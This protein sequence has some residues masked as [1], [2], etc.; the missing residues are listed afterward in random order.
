MRLLAEKGFSR[1]QI[2]QRL[3]ISH[4]DIEIF[5]ESENAPFDYE[6]VD[7]SNNHKI[8]EIID[9]KKI[10]KFWPQRGY[11]TSIRS[12]S[13]EKILPASLNNIALINDKIKFMEWLDDSYTPEQAHVTSTNQASEK[14]TEYIRKRKN[15]CVK[16]VHGVNGHGYWRI[17]SEDNIRFLMNPDAREIGVKTWLYA[18]EMNEMI[19]GFTPMIVMEWLPGPEVSVDILCWKGV[20][21]IHAARTKIDENEQRVES[22]HPVIAHAYELCRKLELNGII[23]VQYRL[24]KHNDWKILEINPRPA[25]GSIHSEDCGFGII[26][27]WGNLLTGKKEPAQ[28]IQ[29]KMTKTI[30]FEK[31]SIIT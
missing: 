1:K 4:P 2:L 20:P 24:S 23:S 27:E 28:I 21:L 31:T 13:A 14:I 11:R 17:M 30:K 7:L 3:K 5:F 12:K 15:V 6:K 26:T 8:N 29:Q 10:D 9:S 25:G 19:R 16:P 18:N 22:D